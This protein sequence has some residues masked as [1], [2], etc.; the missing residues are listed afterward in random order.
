MGEECFAELARG[1]A[2]DADVVVVNTH[3][4]GTHLASGGFVLPP[5]DV[6]VFDE[7][8]AL[9]D[10]MADALGLSLGPGRLQ[11]LARAVRGVLGDGDSP[12]GLDDAAT[13]LARALEPHAGRRLNA[14]DDADVAAAL[15]LAADRVA[16]TLGALR[17][18][19]DEATAAGRRMR[20]VKA[21]GSLAED[22]A[23]ALAPGDDD[24][25]W[26]DG[27]AHA[28]TL[29]VAPVDVGPALAERLWSQVATAVLTSATIP[30]NLAARVGLAQDR[31]DALE[32]GSPFDFE[33]NALLYCA[34]HLPDP[35]HPEHE[36]AM[37]EELVSLVEAAGGRTLALFTSWRAMRAAAE[38]VRARVRWRILT[39]DELPKPALLATFT[40]EETA[41]LFATM[42]FWQGVDVPGPSLSL[43]AIDRV[44]FPRP[45]EPL[46]QAR[47]ERAG[48][49][50]FRSVDLPRA[51][52]LLAR[53]AGRLVRSA[54]ARG[55]VAVLDP[56]LASAGYRW[57]LVR[58]LP[59]MARTRE[60][61]DL[62]AFLAALPAG[63]SPIAS[64]PTS[65]SGQ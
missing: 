39:Q 64:A 54:S 32:V 18:A 46:L 9:E 19:G 13:R 21:A 8:H 24:V 36:A 27:P 29:A 22:L 65:G 15:T 43:V 3:L 52:T 23:A 56:R 2:A 31:H 38:A 59:P 63:G 12:A 40:A 37:H 51:A 62:E 34:A 61:G 41:C 1:R 50:A 45:D 48:P 57:D 60:P 58:A 55:V 33:R 47:R 28:P 17:Q 30:S 11:A 5:H 49:G 10:V 6:V 35:R 44:P 53:G 26:V 16:R 4:Y 14:G 7:A 20:A 42:G 25:A